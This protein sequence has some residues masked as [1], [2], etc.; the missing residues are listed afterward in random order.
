ME[1]IDERIKQLTARMA[2]SSTVNGKLYYRGRLDE[3]ALLK[4][5]IRR[6]K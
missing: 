3:L 6:G 4:R 1:W 2:E 5:T